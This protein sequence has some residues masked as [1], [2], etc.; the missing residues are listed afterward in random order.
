M[1]QLLVETT[2]LT[3]A[4]AAAG[5][6]VAHWSVQI[7]ANVQP[8]P[9]SSQNYDILDW[10]V[11][12]FTLSLAILTGI[13]F[14]VLPGI[15][16]GR[17]QTNDAIRS[18]PGI[19]R[20]S[21]TR[22]RKGLITVQATLAI[23][24]LTASVTMGRSFLRL[25]H[26]DMGFIPKNVI[27]LNVSL[28]GTRYQ[29]NEMERQYYTR[30]L[31]RLRALPGVEAAGVV[32]TLPLVPR[33][34]ADQAATPGYFHAIGA[35]IVAGR[36]FTESDLYTTQP[37]II[38][39][40]EWAKEKGATPA[41]VVGTP[42]QRGEQ[43]LG[44]IV[45]VLKTIRSRGPG[46]PGQPEYYLSQ[47]QGVAGFMSFVVRVRGNTD[48]YL[49]M[50]RD[51]LH[52]VDTGIPVYDVKTLEERL[53]EALA[54][55]RFYTTTVL[56]LA[57]FALLVAVIGIYGVAAYSI[58]QRKFEIG[59]RAAVGASTGDLRSMLVRDGLWPIVVGIVFGLL[60]TIRF[61][62]AFRYLVSTAEPLSV[63]ACLAAAGLLLTTAAVA[64]WTA[65]E[66]IVEL[67][68]TS[69]LRAE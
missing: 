24:L 7:A 44:P 18:Q 35:D 29:T 49:A 39:N 32:S 10:R 13:S 40:E 69:A 2:F 46:L 67:D 54:R 45:G 60:A 48:D 59:V 9:L 41:A 33:Y 22:M 20:S 28:V 25:I 15:V 34:V 47:R 56:F 36:D 37:A 38:V 68:P 4:A 65:T 8:P 5:L 3:L 50:C 23:V 66:R 61:E 43:V 52:H 57:G 27:T 58:G 51:V 1:Q 30:V 63:W 19:T 11:I 12:G 21:A 64:I 14:G 17:M 16:L 53:G 55:P 6:V 62:S 26:A 42:F 31:E